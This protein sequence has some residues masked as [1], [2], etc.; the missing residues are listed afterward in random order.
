MNKTLSMVSLLTI[1]LAPLTVSAAP[2]AH[3]GI[4]ATVSI[5]TDIVGD[6]P[7]DWMASK[8]ESL[9]DQTQTIMVPDKGATFTKNRV[10]N[11][12][13]FEKSEHFYYA[14]KVCGNQSVGG[15][16]VNLIE[17]LKVKNLGGNRYRID[18]RVDR[19]D[20]YSM[21]NES[22]TIP[23]TL[24]LQMCQVYTPKIVTERESWTIIAKKREINFKKHLNGKT[25]TVKTV[26]VMPIF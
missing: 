6:T 8:I 20:G 21:Q 9:N 4:Y 18:G 22:L 2:L 26:K 11:V 12:G 23:G 1:L 10:Y 24:F 19:L 14:G 16:T 17:T 15:E 3:G 13:H 7:S 25:L 5:G